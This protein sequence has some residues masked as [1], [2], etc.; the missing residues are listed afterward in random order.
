MTLIKTV[1]SLARR[2]VRY[3]WPLDQPL[4]QTFVGRQQIRAEARRQAM[5]QL[6][7]VPIDRSTRRQAAREI[8]RKVSHE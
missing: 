5:R 2:A 6:G 7:R 1:V 3:I 4:D 8:S